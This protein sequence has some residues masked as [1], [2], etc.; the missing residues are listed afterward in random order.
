MSGSGAADLIL[1][2]RVS[3]V[4]AT[5]A[6]ARAVAVCGERIA[7][8]GSEHE[9]LALRGP[10]TEV[11]G[12]RRA[13][14]VAGFVDAHLHLVALARRV[15]EVDCSKDRA[16]SVRDVVATIREAAARLA[17]ASWIRAFGYDEFFLE[18]KRPP[19]VAELDAAAPGH[20]VRLLHRTG[21]AVVLNSLGFRRLGL[22]P[23]EVIHEP[24]GLLKSKV[25]AIDGAELTP[26]VREASR[27]LAAAGITT[28]HDPTPGRSM[29]D[30]VALRRWV[31]E[32]EIAQRVVAYG[33][34]DSFAEPR[35]D[36]ERFH[37]PGVKIMVTEASEAEALAA[38]VL[39]ADRAGRQVALH[40][41]EGGPLV[42]AIDAL[43]RLGAARV[44]ERRHRIE[45]A[46]LCPPALCAEIAQSGATIVT[47]PD[48]LRRFG[49]KYASELS[50]EEQAWLYPLRS[51]CLAAVPIA[52]GS[53]API[54]PPCPLANVQAAVERTSERG[55][56]LA[57]SEAIGAAEAVALHTSGGAAAAKLDHLVG[58]VADGMLGDLVLLDADPT[59]VA[60]GEIASI[61][62]QTTVIGGQVRWNR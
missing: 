24:A 52:L 12:D 7:F 8:V 1:L 9:A 61:G 45:H 34:P 59:E 55:H 48:F 29:A 62:V 3:A 13:V 19:T 21:H 58:S 35:A 56:R 38:Q 4:G 33:D 60:P 5:H 37:L 27:R 42:L 43:R 25:A 40:A 15:G 50:E 2:G 39:A 53:D 51:L 23:R 31:D 17:P 22:T 44:R 32:G 10:R 36:S 49:E 57:P 11:L 14:I 6:P 16:R 54:A 20:A 47:H 18:E 46:A 41:V 26:L 30:L 28:V